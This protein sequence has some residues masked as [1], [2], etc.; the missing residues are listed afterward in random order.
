M[1][2]VQQIKCEEVKRVKKK[3]AW[4]ESVNS[5][6][7]KMINIIEELEEN[8]LR[9]NPEA[10]EWSILQIVA[11]VSESIP[12]WTSQI[13]MVINDSTVEWGRGYFDTSRLFA[14]S[15]ANIKN[16]TVKKGIIDLEKIVILVED[17]LLHL[18]DNHLKITASS[19]YEIFN[20]ESVQY[21][22]EKEL[23]NHIK[24]HLEQINRNLLKM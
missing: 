6:I 3:D 8:K 7:N 11:H 23:I 17:L 13:E 4:S 20:G 1:N 2:K 16:L 9:N 5:D 12:F 22:L 19:K 10:E 14:I 21:I 18:K 24:G 15:D